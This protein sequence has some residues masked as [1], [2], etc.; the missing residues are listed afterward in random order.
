MLRLTHHLFFYGSLS[1]KLLSDENR[2][3]KSLVEVTKITSREGNSLVLEEL[4]LEYFRYDIKT[5]FLEQRFEYRDFQH[6][7]ASEIFTGPGHYA[8]PMVI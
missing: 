3:S 5:D 2:I 6:A 4:N 8:D 7:E 1:V